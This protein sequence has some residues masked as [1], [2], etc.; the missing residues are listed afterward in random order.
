MSVNRSADSIYDLTI[1]SPEDIERALNHSAEVD[2]KILDAWD[3]MD[4]KRSSL[5]KAPHY[6]KISAEFASAYWGSLGFSTCPEVVKGMEGCQEL[7]R[8]S[9]GV[10]N[11]TLTT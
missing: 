3:P 4:M 7:L 2:L 5:E 9:V 11:D 6:L 10:C 8:H 1:S